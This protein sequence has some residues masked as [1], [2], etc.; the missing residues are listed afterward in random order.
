MD[1]DDVARRLTSRTKAVCAMHFAGFPAPLEEL[2][3]ICEE[4][5][6]ALLEDAAHAPHSDI[7]GRMLGTF[8]LAG[9]FSFFSNK[10]L[11]CGEGGL[12]ATGDDRVAALARLLRNQGMTSSS[13]SRFTGQTE[14]YAAGSL[15][16]NY[17]FDDQRAALVHSRLRR[18]P[19]DVAR[20]RELT[21]GYRRRLA[22]LEAVSIPYPDA[23]VD[24]STCYV[25]PVLVD[26]S[27][28][29]AVRRKLREDHRI[30]TSILYPAVHELSVYRARNSGLRLP[31]AEHIARAEITLPLFPELDEAAQDRVV[32]ALA[33]ALQ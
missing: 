9:A 31:V 12:L 5:G 17:R 28:R 22:A 8:G 4:R 1:P 18:L 2:R 30:Q 14:A 3:A 27:R 7:D 10:A 15:G 16:F 24:H 20:R 6:V 25:M 13:W 11:A 32:A 26:P 33:E 29:D 21:R 23:A 19:S